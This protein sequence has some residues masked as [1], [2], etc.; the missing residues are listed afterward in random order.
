MTEQAELSIYDFLPAR[1]IDDTLDVF[2]LLREGVPRKRVRLGERL[3]VAT[4]AAPEKSNVMAFS[5]ASAID[6]AR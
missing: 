1:I 3:A 2:L 5:P 6:R 4:D